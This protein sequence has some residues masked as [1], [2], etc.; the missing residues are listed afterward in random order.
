MGELRAWVVLPELRQLW[1]AAEIDILSAL[2]FYSSLPAC[3]APLA[4]PDGCEPA[5]ARRVVR[6]CG[7]GF[8]G[9]ATAHLCRSGAQRIEE[10]WFSVAWPRN[11][12]VLSIVY[13]WS[14][15]DPATAK[16]RLIPAREAAPAQ[17]RRYEESIRVTDHRKMK[18]CR[19]RSTLARQSGV[20]IT[21][22]LAQRSS[23]PLPSSAAC[24][25]T[26]P[27]KLNGRALIFRSS[28]GDFSPG[29]E[30]RGFSPAEIVGI[31]PHFCLAF[32][33]VPQAR[34]CAEGAGG[35]QSADPVTAGLKPRP[36]GLPSQSGR[37]W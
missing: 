7:D 17:I 12:A 33:A 22:R 4:A 27:P 37:A 1:C 19:Q 13:L 9:S 26:S 18:R 8:Q 28:S 21:S 5:Q 16:I 3:P 29:P 15:S 32:R 25:N 6:T 31:P 11:G 14:E 10:R 35:G 24:G 20:S 23:Y 34:D 36:S 30:G 2:P